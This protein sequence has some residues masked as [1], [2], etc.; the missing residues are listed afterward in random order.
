MIALGI[1]VMIKFDFETVPLGSPC[2]DR[3]QGGVTLAATTDIADHF[4]VDHHIAHGIDLA[5][6]SGQE[7]VPVIDDDIDGV[8]TA[9]VKQPILVANAPCY[10]LQAKCFAIHKQNAKHQRKSYHSG[11]DPIDP[12]VRT[13]P[14]YSPL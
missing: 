8:D 2:R 13:H 5:L 7:G 9:V 6:R 4:A 1:I 10:H 11:T 12:F 14:M 3:R